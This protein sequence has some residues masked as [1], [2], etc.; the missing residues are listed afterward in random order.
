MPVR[1]AL[2]EERKAATGGLCLKSPEEQGKDWDTGD[3]PKEP[4][5]RTG[6]KK[7]EKRLK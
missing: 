5:V 2:A 7:E 3:A 1:T 4:S 6:Q